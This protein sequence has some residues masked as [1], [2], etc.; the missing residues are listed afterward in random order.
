MGGRRKTNEEFKE[1]VKDEVGDEYLFLEEYQGYKTKIKVK[2]EK[3]GYIYKIEPT[4][5]LYGNRCPKCAGKVRKDTKYFK[6]E[7][8]ELVGNEYSVLG[9]YVNSSKKIK[10][11]H[12]KCGHEWKVQ[13]SLFVSKNGTRCPNCYG[14]IKRTTEEFK[15]EV[16]ELVGNEYSVL[17]EYINNNENIKMRHNKCGNEWEPVP[18]HFLNGTRCPQCSHPS[19]LKT[20]EEFKEEVKELVGNEHLVLGEYKGRKDDI[21]MYHKKCDNEYLVK[22]TD[23]LNGNRCPICRESK[24]ERKI[25]KWLDKNNIKYKREYRFEDCKDKRPLPFD[26]KINLND[27]FILLEYDGKQHFKPFKYWGGEE[28]FQIT[29]KHDE[30]KNKFCKENDINLIRIPYTEK[31]NINKILINLFNDYPERE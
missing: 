10:M 2:H 26:F 3:C 5:F 18:Y 21:R 29:K 24:S 15:E 30:I 1:E 6:E 20:T 12:N 16:K 25:A 14:N 17:G 9:E 23:F 11:K 31:E 19:Q 22:P 7:V 13:P 28:S 8:K 4:R 27:T